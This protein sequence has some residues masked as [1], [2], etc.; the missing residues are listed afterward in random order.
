MNK[1]VFSILFLN[2]IIHNL[3]S[4]QIIIDSLEKRLQISPNAKQRIDIIN[5]ISFAYNVVNP[6]TAWGISQFA[7][8][9]AKKINYTKGM[10]RAAYCKG[11]A[12]FYLGN[13]DLDIRFTLESL[14]L[15][16]LI[17]DKAGAAGA[18]SGLGIS[19]DFQGQYDLAIE[20][21]QKA[22]E[23]AREV[24][25]IRPLGVALGNLANVYLKKNNPRE[26][27]RLALEAEKF[28]SNHP[29]KR[30]Y[31]YSLNAISKAYLA[32][33]DY[34]N[35]LRYNAE[36]L[37]ISY[38]VKEYDSY[39][40]ALLN[41]GKI[42]R[43]L[44]NYSLAEQNFLESLKVCQQT[45]NRHKIKD[46]CLELADLYGKIGNF[47]QASDYFRLYALTK[48]TIL[49]EANARSIAQMQSLYNIEKKESENN[50]LRKQQEFDKANIREKTWLIFS[51]SG[52][53]LT[54]VAVSLILYYRQLEKEKVNEV[55]RSQN[56]EIN[57]Q[58]IE[59][60]KQAF[61][62]E[63]INHTKNQLFSIIGHD[64]NSP[65][66]SLNAM[67]GLVIDNSLSP[68]DFLKYIPKL[69]NAVE[70]VNFTL[71]NLLLW[72]NS[73]MQGFKINP[74]DFALNKLV[75]EN[76]DLFREVAQNKNIH[77]INQLEKNIEVLADRDHINLVIRNLVNNAIKFT[78]PGGKV[79]LTHTLENGYC[80]VAVEDTGVG[81]KAEHRH[82]IFNKTSQISTYG[83]ANE[84]GTGL[85]L[86]LCQEMIEKNGGKIWI[87][88]LSEK[89]TIFR[90][91]LPLSKKFEMKEAK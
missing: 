40:G 77:L 76:F 19:Y 2:L 70:G 74:K 36:N 59:I 37:K 88:S 91:S 10:A 25:E 67:L 78:H 22:S 39:Q 61:E 43:A 41:E 58:K 84:K 28:L 44:K 53:A 49:T 26:S 89:G 16:E 13:Y 72:A 18:L 86:L 68:E 7:Y 11:S 75:E 31:C 24:G 45:R 83:T 1:I 62:L 69:K 30:A 23:L 87:E 12:S 27:L 63:K 20:K 60:E 8:Q 29:D 82:L 14:R 38:Q 65:M 57:A 55:L 5:E 79:T 48:D 4:Q 34:K 50:L 66:N 17:N 71:Q 54:I 52:F 6:D 33:G 80:I 85:G 73:Q 46:V 9:E 81:I 35:A 42:Y 15:Y 56:T 21:L 51:I 3:Y 90:F 64:L 32:L 47:K